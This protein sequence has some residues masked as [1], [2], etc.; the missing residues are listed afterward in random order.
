MAKKGTLYVCSACGYEASKWYGKCPNCGNWNTFEEIK[1]SLIAP[2]G[3]T[4]TS[5]YTSQPQKLSDIADRTQS[6]VSTTFEEFDRV[7]GR[8]LV[9]GEVVLLSGDPGIGKSTLL[10][11]LAMALSKR[12][13]K[14]VLYVSG[15]ESVDQIKLRA[16]RIS[17]SNISEHD[18]YIVSSDNVDDVLQLVEKTKPS[19]LIVDS[20]QTM[21]SEQVGGFPG[22]LP[23][24]RHATGQLVRLAKAYTI[25]TLL[26]G[27]V[28]KEGDVAGPMLLSHMVDCVLYLEGDRMIGTRILRAFKNRFGD[29]S[30]V[31]IF[32]M[33]EKG[34]VEV[35]DAS[36]HFLDKNRPASPGSCIAVVVEGTRPIL[37]EV[38]AL[39][40]PSSLAFPR[41]VVNGIPQNRVELLLAVLQKSVRLPVDKMDVFVNVVGGFK[42]QENAADLAV[43]LAISSSLRGRALP[44]VAAIAEVGLLGELRNVLLFDRRI[45]EAKK[46]GYKKIVNFPDFKTVSDVVKSL[47]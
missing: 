3:K 33:E 21:Q 19:L 41:R 27:H 40:V 14:S 2:K 47:L 6:R 43:S 1:L 32:V 11:Q 18:L 24:I 34:L 45:S 42:I 7:L 23:Q 38:Q 31:G 13:N 25:P 37:V 44:Q 26:V 22:S 4:T 29:V 10:L 39:C 9:Q 36:S 46:F 17:T 35:K 15:E 12:Q 16:L 28:T 30:E 8:G 20:I 5:T